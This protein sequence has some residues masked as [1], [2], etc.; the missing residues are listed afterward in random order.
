MANVS[1]FCFLASY[2][3]A[4][5]LELTRLLRRS[6]IS[7]IVMLLFA[8]AGFVAHTLFLWDT[9]Q[10]KDLPPLLGSSP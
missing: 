7:R 1:V 2:A 4:F 8:V 3:I 5:S 9:G 6:S 10:E